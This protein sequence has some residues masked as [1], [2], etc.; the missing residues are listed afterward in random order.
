MDISISFSFF[1]GGGWFDFSFFFFFFFLPFSAL[2]PGSQPEN[3]GANS[4][5]VNQ[6]DRVDNAK[7]AA[8]QAKEAADASKSHAMK[9]KQA[10]K[11]N[12]AGLAAMEK[13]RNDAGAPAK[14]AT[15]QSQYAIRKALE[16]R[17]EADK[18]TD[19]N[20]KQEANAAAE[21]AARD[22]DESKTA[23]VEAQAALK[24]LADRVDREKQVLADMERVKVIKEK[25]TWTL[26]GMF[27][28]NSHPHTQGQ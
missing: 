9:V 23:N 8:E 22:A 26:K 25:K 10:V 13:A 18:V 28:R 5:T 20:A 27:A 11:D 16:A 12:V 19:D 15:E 24:T 1:E 6:T 4:Q 17:G 14:K 2:S 3:R 7:A 21:H